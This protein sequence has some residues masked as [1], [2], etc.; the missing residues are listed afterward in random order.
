MGGEME[1][2]D[3]I[4]MYDPEKELWKK[5]DKR[6]AVPRKSFVAITLPEFFQCSANIK[7]VNGGS[8]QRLY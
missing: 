6:L 7:D 2:M 5:K 1:D 3:T 4:F 8:S